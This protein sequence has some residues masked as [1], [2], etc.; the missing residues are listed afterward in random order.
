REAPAKTTSTV[1]FASSHCSFS[2]ELDQ[3]VERGTLQ[4]HRAS[5]PP[6]LDL[7]QA[8]TPAERR[9]EPFSLSDPAGCGRLFQGT[10]GLVHVPLGDEGVDDLVRLRQ[11]SFRSRGT[12]GQTG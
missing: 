1:P 8:D 12:V 3:I 7:R 9:N 4:R 11:E 6:L 2:G 5:Q 10:R